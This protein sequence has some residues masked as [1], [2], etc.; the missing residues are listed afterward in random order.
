MNRQPIV[1]KALHRKL[2][3]EQHLTNWK[4]EVNLDI[5]YK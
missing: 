1:H 4:P 3:I 5:L 2:K